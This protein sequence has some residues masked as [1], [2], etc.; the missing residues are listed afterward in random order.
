[1]KSFKNNPKIFITGNGSRWIQYRIIIPREN[2]S[3]E[4][5]GSAMINEAIE[6]PIHDDQ[7][8]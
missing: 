1:M 6:I 8:S 2:G 4:I 5:K 7:E 3:T